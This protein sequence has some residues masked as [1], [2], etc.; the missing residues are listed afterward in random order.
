MREMEIIFPSQSAAGTAAT[1]LR[2]NLQPLDNVHAEHTT[3]K[4]DFWRNLPLSIA[5]SS[6]NFLISSNDNW[7]A[8]A[9]CSADKPIARRRRAVAF[10]SSLAPSARPS[11][12]PSARPSQPFSSFFSTIGKTF[13]PAI[14]IP[15]LDNAALIAQIL[16][17]TDI[18]ILFR[19]G[20]LIYIQAFPGI[21]QT[22]GL[23]CLADLTGLEKLDPFIQIVH[24]QLIEVVHAEQIILREYVSG[25]AISLAT[26]RDFVTEEEFTL[27]VRE[28]SGYH[29]A[30]AVLGTSSCHDIHN[31]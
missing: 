17:V 13:L 30:D 15:R 11:S 25:F 10:F 20:Q 7:V 1:E 24:R 12:R 9:T 4:G 3:I 23:G 2:E 5:K 6:Y 22:W 28:F 27:S 14:I 19:Y 29:S 8:A 26:L 31:P 21:C 18:I 16:H